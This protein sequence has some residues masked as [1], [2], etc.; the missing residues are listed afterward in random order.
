MLDKGYIRAS[1]SPWGTQV[2]FVKKK[3]GT[4]GLC[5]HYMQLNK[6]TIKNK[7]MLS[8]ID[9]LFNQLKGT[10]MLSKIDM[11]LGCHLRLD[12]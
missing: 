2:L 5:I 1:V 9:D 8:R 11:R 6:V 10:T 3:D 12:Y 4:L 7:Y